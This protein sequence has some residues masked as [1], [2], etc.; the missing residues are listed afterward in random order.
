MIKTK[1]AKNKMQQAGVEVRHVK[2]SLKMWADRLENYKEPFVAQAKADKLWYADN[3]AN[4]ARELLSIRERLI[5]TTGYNYLQHYS[6]G[7][8]KEKSKRVQPQQPAQTEVVEPAS[9][10]A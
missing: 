8:K 4:A 9:L 7:M 5:N 6:V 1:A 3:L 2:G 10:V